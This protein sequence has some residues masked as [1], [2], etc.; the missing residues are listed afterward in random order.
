MIAR[1]YCRLRRKI[2]HLLGDR[3]GDTFW[4]NMM[5]TREVLPRLRDRFDP[6]HVPSIS[7][8]INTDCNYRCSFCPQSTRRRPSRFMTRDAFRRVVAD[9]AGMSFD[10]LVVLSVNNEPFLH[11]LLLEFCATLSEQLPGAR[12]HLIS[13][14][15]LVTESHLKFLAALERPPSIDINDYTN[16]HKI[17]ARLSTIAASLPGAENMRIVIRPRSRDEVLS[18]RAGNQP[19]C[20]TKAG[21]YRNVICTWPF[22]SMFVAADLRAFLCCSDYHHEMIMGDLG[23]QSIMEVWTGAKYAELRRKMLETQRAGIP[24]CRG[25][26]A[27]WFSLPEH[28]A[29]LRKPESGNKEE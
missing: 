27:E 1:T 29:E 22:M 26:D 13:N 25:C 6:D 8:E 24:M 9:L 19:G 12:T 15:S 4:S 16:D 20:K 18:N 7:I 5:A 17:A 21:D 3:R 23:S 10:G 11:P 2:C 14:G 28:C